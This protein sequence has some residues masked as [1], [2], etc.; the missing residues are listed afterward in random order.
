[1]CEEYSERHASK[2]IAVMSC[3]GSCLRKCEGLSI[4]GRG[5]VSSHGA[6]SRV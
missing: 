5:G 1:V 3:D 6:R 4:S 2:P